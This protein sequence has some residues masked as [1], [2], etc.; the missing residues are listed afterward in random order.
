M[1]FV[2]GFFTGLMAGIIIIGLAI[3]N[4]FNELEK[5]NRML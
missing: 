3:D 1:L 2:T 4:K 5:E